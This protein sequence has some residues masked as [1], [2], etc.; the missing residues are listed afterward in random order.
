MN[1]SEQPQ[2]EQPAL[3]RDSDRLRPR[4]HPQL[5]EDRFDMLVDRAGREGELAS[6]LFARLSLGHQLQHLPLAVG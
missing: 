6:D 5:I 4:V 3:G 2:L 1:A